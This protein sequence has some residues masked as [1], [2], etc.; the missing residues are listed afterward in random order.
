MSEK[1]EKVKDY[2]DRGLWGMARVQNAVKKH[3]ITPME[4]E[5]ITGQ[6]YQEDTI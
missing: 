4:F 1:Y 3:W 6:V 5:E 2:F